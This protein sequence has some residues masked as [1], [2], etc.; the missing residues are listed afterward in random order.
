MCK[1]AAMNRALRV[2]ITKAKGPANL[3]RL[4]RT[5]PQVITNWQSRGVSV[6]KCRAVVRVTNDPRVTLAKLRPD[7]FRR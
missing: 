5:T 7:I 6:L 1:L 2:A 4:L 3:A